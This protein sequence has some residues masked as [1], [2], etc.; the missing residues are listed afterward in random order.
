MTTSTRQLYLSVVY[1]IIFGKLPQN[2]G[3]LQFISMSSLLAFVQTSSADKG[4]IKWQ[5][6]STVSHII[7]QSSI[8]NFS[9]AQFYIF[10][11]VSH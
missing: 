8:H 1:A 5:K 9:R 11:K 7:M 10:Q 6:A 4:G 3:I 2:K